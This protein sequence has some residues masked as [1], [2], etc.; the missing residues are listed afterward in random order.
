[1]LLRQAGTISP[2][3][4]PHTDVSFPKYMV[5][6][7]FTRKRKNGLWPLEVF[8]NQI[9]MKFLGLNFWNQLAKHDPLA[10]SELLPSSFDSIRGLVDAL[11]TVIDEVKSTNLKSSVMITHS[12]SDSDI[13]LEDGIYLSKTRKR[14]PKKRLSGT[15]LKKTL[16]LSVSSELE[17]DVAEGAVMDRFVRPEEAMSHILRHSPSSSHRSNSPGGGA[18][19]SM[20]SSR[21]ASP[22]LIDG[23][24]MSESS[25]A[26][27]T[28]SGLQWQDTSTPS[29]SPLVQPA[30]SDEAVSDLQLPPPPPPSSNPNQGGG[31]T[32]GST[33]G[34]ACGS[35]SA[36]GGNTGNL[37][38]LSAALASAMFHMRGLKILVVEDSLFQR[39]MMA[40]KLHSVSKN[41]GATDTTSGGDKD[42]D[43]GSVSSGS[44]AIPSNTESGD[45]KALAGSPLPAPFLGWGG[46]GGG[47]GSVSSGSSSDFSPCVPVHRPSGT[48]D[49]EQVTNGAWNVTEARNGEEAIRLIINSQGGFDVIFVDENLQGSGGYLLGHEVR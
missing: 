40:K 11:C 6:N 15:K 30:K 34:S 32:S 7:F 22:Q 33:S 13:F 48:I 4:A 45:G 26:S 18:F 41:A 10:A 21:A 37:P 47:G 38:T 24:D 49:M 44:R 36:S 31:S 42:S 12:D 27:P 29:A 35:G 39:K 1:M 20:Q 14:A 8:R 9:K 25:T 17:V 46:G 43:A 23:H 28:V 5:E 16:L 19:S 2:D 3:S